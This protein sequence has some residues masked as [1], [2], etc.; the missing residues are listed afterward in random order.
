[1]I[2]LQTFLNDPMTLYNEWQTVLFVVC[3]SIVF[4]TF[5]GFPYLTLKLR[6]G[7]QARVVVYVQGKI[8]YDEEPKWQLIHHKVH[9][10]GTLVGYTNV[11]L[12][13]LLDL[14]VVFSG[15]IYIFTKYDNIKY[16][17][18]KM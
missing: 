5:K 17:T 11:C 9:M 3:V 2:W 14:F 6:T 10:P 1:M 15:R 8:S 18:R 12:G 4:L 7:G 16:Y 13:M